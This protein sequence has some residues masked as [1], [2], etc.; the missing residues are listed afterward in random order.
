MAGSQGNMVSWGSYGRH[1]PHSV[2]YSYIFF[3]IMAAQVEQGRGPRKR[4][5]TPVKLQNWRQD[6]RCANKRTMKGRRAV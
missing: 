3:V 1:M 6:Q 2:T 5:G 4:N